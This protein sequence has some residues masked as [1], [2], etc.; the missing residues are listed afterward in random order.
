MKA[1]DPDVPVTGVR[2]LSDYVTSSIAQP[3]FTAILLAVFAG[4]ALLLT[5]IGLYGVISYSVSQRTHEIGIR[6]ALGA[7]P[8]DV[9]ALVLRQGMLMTLMGLGVGAVLALIAERLLAHWLSAIIFGISAFDPVTYISVP[10]FLAVVALLATW[11]P[12]R[13]AMSVDPIIAL[14]YE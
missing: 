13:R 10:V 8:G 2:L 12:A 9:L 3:R 4:V 14:R 11:F 1:L 6:L 5:A 7:L